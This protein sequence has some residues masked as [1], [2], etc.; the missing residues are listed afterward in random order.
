MLCM[1]GEAFDE[2][3]DDVCGAVMNIRPKG[4][5]IGIWTGDGNRTQSIMEIGLV[6]SAKFKALLLY[7]LFVFSQRIK[8]RLN[9]PAKVM[10]GYQLH[11][12]LTVKNSSVIKN[13]FQV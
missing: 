5:K 3:S 13:R 6:V 9:I 8:S 2:F 7:L 1:I 11:R 4:D 10:I 12:D